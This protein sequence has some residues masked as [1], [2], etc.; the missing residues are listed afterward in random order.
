MREY[1]GGNGGCVLLYDDP[2]QNADGQSRYKTGE[3]CSDLTSAMNNRTSTNQNPSVP[4]AAVLVAK[5][6]QSMFTDRQLVDFMF[7]SDR[8][9][10]FTTIYLVTSDNAYALRNDNVQS[11]N[12]SDYYND[13]GNNGNFRSNTT[14]GR[15]VR[16]AESLLGNKYDNLTGMAYMC[17]QMDVGISVLQC[18]SDLTSNLLNFQKV[19]AC[20]VTEIGHSEIRKTLCGE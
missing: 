15:F 13:L 11:M 4:C 19:D 16:E 20:K 12:F 1:V 17:N 10:K 6:G 9:N 2:S 14:G 7:Y 3:M 8:N 18:T 5:E